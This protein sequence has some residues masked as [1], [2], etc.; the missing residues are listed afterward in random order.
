MNNTSRTVLIL[1]STLA[2]FLYDM[3]SGAIYGLLGFVIGLFLE[4]L[5][6]SSD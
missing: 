5:F 6:S 3:P 1:L 2:T 4:M